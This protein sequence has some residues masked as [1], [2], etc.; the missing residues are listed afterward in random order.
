MKFYTWIAL[1]AFSGSALA[2]TC[3]TANLKTQTLKR[4]LIASVDR[5]KADYGSNPDLLL[6]QFEALT[7]DLSASREL[8]EISEST[9][10]H[11]MGKGFTKEIYSLQDK[12]SVLMGIV[13][14]RGFKL[15]QEQYVAPNN[16]W[17]EAANALE[18]DIITKR[19]S[20]KLALTSSVADKQ[21]KEREKKAKLSAE[22]K[23]LEEM[24]ALVNKANQA[25][26]EN[27]KLAQSVNQAK[28][29]LNEQQNKIRRESTQQVNRSSSYREGKTTSYVKKHN[30][31]CLSER[32]FDH[33]ISLLTQ[34]VRKPANYCYE[35]AYDVDVIVLDYGMLGKSK[36]KAV[37]DETVMWVTTESL[38]RR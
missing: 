21:L 23:E 8:A 19:E 29:S 18:K 33:Q 30:L 15:F 13:G 1:L 11:C 20:I 25:E 10:K 9:L 12:N 22:M 28:K 7:K 5:I 35:T 6:K 3:S 32:Q 24:K 36:V 14:Y 27:R 38:G 31:F 4:R 2:G 26:S 34:G 37:T 17:T 16:T